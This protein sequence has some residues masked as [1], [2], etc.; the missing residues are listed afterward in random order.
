MYLCQPDLSMLALRVVTPRVFVIL[1]GSFRSRIETVPTLMG[2]SDSWG[3]HSPQCWGP[4]FN[5]KYIMHAVTWYWIRAANMPG[6]CANHYT[7]CVSRHTCK[8]VTRISTKAECHGISHWGQTLM[9]PNIGLQAALLEI[10]LWLLGVKYGLGDVLLTTS[11]SI[12]LH[13][14]HD[15]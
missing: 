2:F 4:G 10:P 11:L 12:L 9:P 8:I 5:T 7:I 6:G 3:I 1:S 13:I 15:Q 14:N